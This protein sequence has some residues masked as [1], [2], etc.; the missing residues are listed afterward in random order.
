[1]GSKTISLKD[2]A[3]ERL[4]SLKTGDKSFSDVVI[5]ITGEGSGNFENL[6]G[7]DSGTTVEELTET[8]RKEAERNEK[9]ENLLRG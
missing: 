1:M 3:Y 9:R 2:E 6:I 7:A 4:K 8:R 5:E